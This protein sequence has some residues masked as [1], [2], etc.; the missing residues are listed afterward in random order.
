M[1]RI[2][3][4]II[5][6]NHLRYN[7]C[8]FGVPFL[9]TFYTGFIYDDKIIFF[10][11]NNKYESIEWDKIFCW[12]KSVKYLFYLILILFYSFLFLFSISEFY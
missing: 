9:K 3:V 10:Y 12:K 8:V 2:F 1:A 6:S 5:Y 11:S 7:N 4:T